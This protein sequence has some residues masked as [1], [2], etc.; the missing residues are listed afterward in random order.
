MRALFLA[1][2]TV[3]A[4]I[5]TGPAV[6]ADMQVPAY[7]APMPTVLPPTWTGFYFGGHVGG[8][9]GTKELSISERE[10]V[11]FPANVNGFLGGV[12]AGYNFQTGWVVLGI[13]GDFSWADIKGSSF[14]G[15]FAA[16]TNWTATLTGRIGG[17]VDHALLYL[18]GGIA[19]AHDKY[20]FDFIANA[21]ETRTGF[22][23]GGGIEYAFTRNWSGKVEYN[24]MD[25]GNKDVNFCVKSECEALSVL[26]RLHQMKV[27]LN[28]RF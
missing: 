7:K 3:A 13:E 6:A 12:Q 21:T 22:V 5:A 16:K 25:F 26:Q 18:K 8:G 19:W 28:Y 11:A 1:G 15:L 24:Y 14:E 27:G 4:I 10:E 2:V 9:W 23:V 20:S 17:T